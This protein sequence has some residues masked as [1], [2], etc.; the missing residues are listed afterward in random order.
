MN[1][2]LLE[3]F[4]SVYNKILQW[5]E[6]SL[7]L[8]AAENITSEFTRL[9]KTTFLQE[10]YLLG[11]VSQ[12][13]NDN[14]FY[15]SENIYEIYKLLQKQCTKMFNCKYADART[16]SGI[17][18]IVTILMALFDVGDTILVT[19]PEYGGHS[20]M[21]IICERLGLNVILL[22]YDYVRKDFDYEKINSTLDNEN[23]KG[24]LI[25]LSDMLEH[26]Q[27]N[28]LHIKDE[29]VLYDAT[30]VLGL[31]ATGYIDNPFNW[32][33]ESKN[34]ILMGATHKTIPGPTSG[35]IM[36]NNM[37]LV[38][39]IDLKINPDYLRNVQLDNI[40]CLLFALLELEQ[41]GNDYFLRMKS[42]INTTAKLL[43]CDNIQVI[44]TRNNLYSC[45]HQLWLHIGERNL[46]FFERNAIAVG[47]SLNIRRKKVYGNNGVRLG[48]QQVA[49]YNWN[50]N[51]AKL[52]S[53]IL[54]DLCD[55]NCNYK[56]IQKLMEALSPKKVY[57]TFDALTLKKVITELHNSYVD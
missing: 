14:N 19:A 23:I 42:L 18:A 3:E 54:L 48:F 26:P 50:E 2:G 55:E 53:K 10:K 29:I 47:V 35:L 16:L 40:V 45:T 57:F 30:Q 34:F 17:N 1:N 12:Y 46:D 8:C 7:P 38:K 32:F 20:S 24:I 52:I 28:K 27:L 39:K 13:S 51:D 4:L 6:H 43:E 56:Q 31:I 5:E 25:A 37:D 21:P 36:S 9:P 22:P 11:G 44:K 15:G 33:S 49:R 41:F